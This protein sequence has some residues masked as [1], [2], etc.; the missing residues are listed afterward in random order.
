MLISDVLYGRGLL[1]SAA[2]SGICVFSGIIGCSSS[3]LRKSHNFALG[4]GIS[5]YWVAEM[6]V[7]ST[8]PTDA[9]NEP[10]QVFIEVYEGQ[11]RVH[12]WDGTSQEPVTTLIG[13]TPG[14]VAK[15]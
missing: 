10:S 1:T 9:E 12:V 5:V 11:L 14:V 4:G 13:R 7:S 2:D 8:N 15:T 3:K 6:T